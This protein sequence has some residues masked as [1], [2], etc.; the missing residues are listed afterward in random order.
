MKFQVGCLKAVNSAIIVDMSICGAIS[1]AIALPLIMGMIIISALIL[2]LIE[3]QSTIKYQ[4]AK[5]LSFL[6]K[7]S[8]YRFAF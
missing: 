4:I 5:W 6:T 2:E 1:L 8:F 7:N 3:T